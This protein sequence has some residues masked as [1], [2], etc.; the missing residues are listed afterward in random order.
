MGQSG[1]LRKDH[2][3]G[4]TSNIP[5]IAIIRD[6]PHVVISPDARM[7]LQDVACSG[8]MSLEINVLLTRGFTPH[9]NMYRGRLHA[10]LRSP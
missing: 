10:R 9:T 1:S 7:P 8:G 6:R 4:S 3:I 2:A 5:E